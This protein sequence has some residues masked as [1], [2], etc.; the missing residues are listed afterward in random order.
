MVHESPQDTANEMRLF[1]GTKTD[2]VDTICKQNFDWRVPIKHGKKYGH[3]S[4]FAVKASLSHRYTETG[5]DG[6]SKSM[7]LARVLV[8]S[9]TAG[10]SHYRR[11][12]GKGTAPESDLYDSCVDDVANPSIFVV[13]NMDQ[14]YPEYVVKYVTTQLQD[15]KPGPLS[16]H[17]GSVTAV[18]SL[19]SN[20]QLSKPS[21]GYPLEHSINRGAGNSSKKLRS[22]ELLS[23]STLNAQRPNTAATKSTVSPDNPRSSRERLSCNSDI[24]LLTSASSSSMQRPKTAPTKPV[25]LANERGAS[26]RVRVNSMLFSSKS[27]VLGP[28]APPERPP[29]NLANRRSPKKSLGVNQVL[30]SSTLNAQRLNTSTNNLSPNVADETVSSKSLRCNMTRPSSSGRLRKKGVLSSSSSNVTDTRL[31]NGSFICNRTLS[32]SLNVEQPKTGP[33]RHPVTVANRSGSIGSLDSSNSNFQRPIKA[34]S[35]LTLTNERGLRRRLKINQVLSSPVRNLPL[36]TALSKH[37]RNKEYPRNTDSSLGCERNS[38]ERL[39]T[40]QG[41]SFST[42]HVLLPKTATRNHELSLAGTSLPSRILS[43]NEVVQKP[44]AV[45]G[46]LSTNLFDE[47]S[48]RGSLRLQRPNQVPPRPSVNVDYRKTASGSLEL[49][50]GLAFPTS[51]VNRVN[52]SSEVFPSTPLNR[53]GSIR[54]LRTDTQLTSPTSNFQQLKAVLERP[55]ENPIKPSRSV[56]RSSFEQPVTAHEQF[57]ANVPNSKLG[58]EY[59]NDN[60]LLLS[61]TLDLQ[62]SVTSAEPHIRAAKGTLDTDNEPSSL[63]TNSPRHLPTSSGSSVIQRSSKPNAGP[64][65]TKQNNANC[66]SCLIL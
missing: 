29:L 15:P 9:Y 48:Y 11:P 23:S 33:A 20:V 18:S 24:Q 31:S 19:T 66:C 1:H 6:E 22:T 7:F 61:S 56:R 65:D 63:M 57:N 64:S 43:S 37:S 3:G 34:P 4:Y 58:S 10:K 41:S 36:R 25:T 52:T 44:K 14:Y 40:N 12:P 13:F 17:L 60:Q 2:L 30:P 59:V 32:S 55:Q 26:G 8:G 62:E 54:S 38:R 51:T 27:N 50:K 21:P 53:K 47:R 28:N 42:S 46:N 49:S 16:R 45:P 5:I 39:R 35:A